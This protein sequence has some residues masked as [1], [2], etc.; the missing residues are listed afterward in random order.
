MAIPIQAAPTYLL[1]LPSNGREVKYRP[2]LVKEQ[3]VLTIAKESEDSRQQMRSIRDMLVAV[4]QEFPENKDLKIDDLPMYDI[5]YLFINIRK[6]SVGETV[7]IS[8]K[9]NREDCEGGGTGK[10][11]V[12]L[13]DVKVSEVPDRDTTVMISDEVGVVLRDPKFGDM[14]MYQKVDEVEQ[15]VEVLKNSIVTIFDAEST[16]EADDISNK[17]LSDFVDSL[18]FPQLEM[19]GAYFDGMPKL[20]H[21]VNFNCNICGESNSVNLEGLQS[22]F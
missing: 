20:S 16:Y 13:D 1:E 12:N 4:T 9:C 7:E 22:F 2:F 17:D 14:K 18:T 19:L 8:L 15:P 6:V 21:E 3:K 10:V 11:T 5:E